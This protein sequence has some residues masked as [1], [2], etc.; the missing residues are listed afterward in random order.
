[1]RVAFENGDPVG[2]VILDFDAPK[3]PVPDVPRKPWRLGDVRETTA[4][5]PGLRRRNE[6]GLVRSDDELGPVVGVEFHQQATH[7]GFGGRRAYVQSGGDIAVGQPPAHLDENLKLTI[8][9]PIELDWCR[10]AGHL[11]SLHELRDELAG[12]AG[13]QKRLT[14]H[15][16]PDAGR[17]FFGAGVFEQEP[18]GASPQ[19]VIYVLVKIER[20]QHQHSGRRTLCPCRCHVCRGCGAVRRVGTDWP[21]RATD[22]VWFCVGL[23][24]VTDDVAI[25]ASA[26]PFEAFYERS[27]ARAMRPAVLVARDDTPAEDLVQEVFASMFGRYE[28]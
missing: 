25:L 15:Q 8:G 2:I 23:S 28:S 17:Q 6:A 5:A 4:A 3:M 22:S 19:S 24:V 7:M 26:E 21:G 13:R 20:G 16:C 11:G 27:D 12:D 14:G 9:E 10:R 1:M 18:A